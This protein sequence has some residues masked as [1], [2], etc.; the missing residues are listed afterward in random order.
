MSG[1]K[2]SPNLASGIL[3]LWDDGRVYKEHETWIPLVIRFR[4]REKPMNLASIGDV[5]FQFKDL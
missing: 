5:R 3:R 4:A 2:L 1:L